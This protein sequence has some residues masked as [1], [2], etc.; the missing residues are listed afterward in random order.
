M[1]WKLPLCAFVISSLCSVWML[2]HRLEREACGLSP[3]QA[4]AMVIERLRHDGQSAHTL[5]AATPAG[6][7]G[8]AFVL[9]APDAQWAYEVRSDW[10]RGVRVARQR[11]A[12]GD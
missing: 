10:R 7:C 4:R 2:H 1:H 8:F 12:A 3:E 6:V 9:H 11:R 5:G